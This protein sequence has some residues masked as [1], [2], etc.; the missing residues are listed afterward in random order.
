MSP[1]LQRFASQL[2]VSCQPVPG[3]PLDQPES[4]VGFALAALASGAK[5]LR[6]EGVANLAAVRQ[7]TDAPIIGL[8]KRDLDSTP[9][10]ITPLEED[11]AALAAAG[12]DIIAFDGTDR[13]RP[14]SAARLC[15]LVRATGRLA[16]ADIATKAEAE[17]AIA[18]GADIIGTTMSGY[19]GGP[20]PSEPDFELLADCVK[21]GHPVIAEG[22]VRTPSQ[23]AEAIRLGAHGV[24]VGSAITRPEH[25]TRWFCAAIEAARAARAAP[26]LAFDLGGSKTLVA[27]VSGSRILAAHQ[28]P[29]PRELSA[30]GWCDRIT[31]L[32]A[33]FADAYDRVAG[34]VTGVIKGGRWTALNPATLPVPAGFALDE[35]LALRLER[36]VTLINDGQAAAWGEYRYGAGQGRN[37]IFL[38]VSTGI[39][40]GVVLDGKLCIGRSGLAGSVGISRLIDADGGGVYAESAASGPMLAAAA[41]ELGIAN[42]PALFAAAETGHAGA[43]AAIDRSAA[44]VSAL[45]GNLQLLFDPDLFIIGGG[46]GLQPSYRRRL[47]TRLAELPPLVRPEIRAAVLGKHAGVIGAADLAGRM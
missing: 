2:L 46:I 28:A 44:V 31:A 16:M 30:E 11:I 32:A 41:R 42:V 6:I 47:E 27:L 36:P 35:A 4:V 26:V 45:I 34:C 3:G 43:A 39:G 19:T 8:I 23:A 38:T 7:A 37:M 10:R 29:T 9:V 33:D 21:L 15:A 22:R 20:E 40:G 5:G 24:V 14:V 18:Y 25:I 13:V 17:A 1:I 12:A